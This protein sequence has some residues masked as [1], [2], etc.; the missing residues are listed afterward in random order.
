VEA[1]VGWV[2]GAPC[3]VVRYGDEVGGAWAS[4]EGR[5]PIVLGW[6][7]IN[8]NNFELIQIF[9]KETWID[10]LKNALPVLEKFQIKYIFE[11]NQIRNNFTYCNFSKFR[12][13]FQLKIREGSRGWI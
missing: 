10:S 5:G 3:A 7:K 2:N 13:E 8:S 11:G 9:S 4:V 6:P 12:I 1:G